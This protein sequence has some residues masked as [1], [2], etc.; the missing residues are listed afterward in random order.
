MYW[1]IFVIVINCNHVW[2]GLGS[3]RT[4]EVES[5]G[6]LSTFP[7][8]PLHSGGREDQKLAVGDVELHPPAPK[9]QEVWYHPG[10]RGSTQVVFDVG[11][12]MTS[13]PGPSL[14]LNQGR[15]YLARVS[16]DEEFRDGWI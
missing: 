1:M 6:G 16:E 7:G 11:S 9:F 12:R 2:V 8:L 14:R 10:F 13:T 4:P 3:Q 15:C 5:R